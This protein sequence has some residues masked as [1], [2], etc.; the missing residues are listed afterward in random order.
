MYNM[1]ILLDWYKAADRED[2]EYDVNKD[3]KAMQA[4]NLVQRSGKIYRVVPMVRDYVR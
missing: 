1:Q 2:L 4:L 3:V